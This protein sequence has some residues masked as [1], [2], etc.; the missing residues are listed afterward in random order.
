MAATI[1]R[2]KTPSILQ[3]HVSECGAACLGMVLGYFGRY[4][5]LAVLREACEV[6]RDGSSAASL[7]RASSKFG[8]NC[9]GLGLRADQLNQK[10][11]PMILFW[12]YS[13]F[14]VLEGFNGDGKVFLNDPA[15]G[16]RQ[17]N[18]EEFVRGY[19]GIA[20]Q[21]E[22]GKDFRASSGGEAQFGLL[23]RMGE[24]LRGLWP[25]IGWLA[26]CATLLIIL[27]LVIPFSLEAF[28]NQFLSG[29]EVRAGLVAT[30][31]ILC[32]ALTYIVALLKS[33]FL[34]RMAIRTSVSSYDGAFTRLLSLP[35]D[36]FAH[37]LVGDI[38]DRVSSNDRIGKNLTDQML[39]QMIDMA[40]NIILFLV[41]LTVNVWLTMIVIAL[42]ILHGIS[43]SFLNVKMNSSS[44]TLRREQG[45]LLSIGMQIL[46]GSENLRITGASDRVFASWSGQ[47]ARELQ[48]R[49][50][51]T[52]LS[53]VNS[54]L[55][56]FITMLR[57]AA[58]LGVGGWLVMVGEMSIGA[59]VA[60]Y[61]LAEM[62]MLPLARFFDFSEQW[63]A[64]LI[65]FQRSD[66]ITATKQ[67]AAFGRREQVSDNI[68][69]FNGQLQLAGHLELRGI[70]MGF[71]KSRPPLIKN[72]N[73]T[74]E[75]GQ[76]VA[77][78]GPSGSGKSTIAR[79]V[80]G[81]YRP[82]EGEVLFDGY[83]REDIPEEVMRRS[84]SMVDQDVVLFPASVRDN[85]T[86]WNAEIPDEAVYSAARDACIHDDILLRS[87]GYS[88]MVKE[89]GDNFSGGERQRM[90][91]ARALV[92]S[93]TLIILDEATSS[94]DPSTEEKVDEALRRRGVSCLIIAH[95]LSTVSDCD[96]IVVL[97]DG[98]VVQWGTHEELIAAEE[99]V[100][101]QLVRSGK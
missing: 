36:F 60:F 58:I 62:F 28:I 33:R 87:Q 34:Y 82:W 24:L 90:E 56:V 54:S 7:V 19:S 13:H 74:I 35:F 20:L 49:Q 40:I 71:N 55:P 8:L 15:I 72:F 39:A 29:E 88:T 81:I 68:V 73:L 44:E 53:S 69:T 83:I 18:Q 9:K 22:R 91:I 14:V 17:L 11:P 41:M 3:M 50:S 95:R 94:L 47:Q 5:P 97:Q 48:A 96:L 23:S 1:N 100:Y 77:I 101:V 52:N 21:F 10:K 92:G 99:G 57:S 98:H 66:D 38:T 79:L 61:F 45:M 67:D 16:R 76:R 78:V 51:V 59:L 12:Q 2:V 64:L 37:R 4:V 27:S 85:I 89:N 46:G 63:S 43:T 6:S 80:A 26:V 86:L 84:I 32:G 42:S 93:P 65:D 75:P 70:T 25:S 30:I 31:L